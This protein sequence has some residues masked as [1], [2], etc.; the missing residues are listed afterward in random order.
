MKEDEQGWNL[1]LPTLLLAYW[2]SHHA[3]TRVTP[4]EL[5]FGRNPCLP[6]DV[7]FSIP[8]AV[9]DPSQY[10]EILKRQQA[11]ERVLQ[12]MELQQLRQKENY[13]DGV[14]GRAY[15]VENY[16][17]GVRGRAYVVEN[18]DDGVR[19]R[20]Y[21]VENYDDGVRGR[22]YVVENYDD[23]VRGRA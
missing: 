9:E 20:A 8:G 2:T 12:Y 7:L 22:A 17:D 13:D 19:G 15:V 3:T 21:V 18:Y 14:R 16:D 6:E 10:A 4:S 1:L 23:G 5:M 11:R